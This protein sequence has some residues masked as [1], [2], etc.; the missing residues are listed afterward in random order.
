MT[1]GT[2]EIYRSANGDRWSL[3]LDANLGRVFIKHEANIPSGGR[4]TEFD[5]GLFLNGPRGSPEHQ[6]LVRLIGTLVEHSPDA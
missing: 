3:A 4:V 6:A 2:R 1:V 5:L